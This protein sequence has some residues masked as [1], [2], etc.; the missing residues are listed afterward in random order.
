MLN[1][2]QPWVIARM[3]ALSLAETD[4][5]RLSWLAEANASYRNAWDA[6]DKT[7]FH[8]VREYERWLIGRRAFIRDVLGPEDPGT[9]GDV[10]EV[11][12]AK[13][14]QD[15]L[16]EYKIVVKGVITGVT[17]GLSPQIDILIVDPS[18][19]E[20]L[21]ELKAIPVDLVVAAFECKLSLRVGD[22]AK[23]IGTAR[24]LKPE[25]RKKA[26]DPITC[27]PIFYGLLGLGCAIENRDKLPH[28]SVL[29]AI[30]RHSGELANSLDMLDAVVV[31]ETFCVTANPTILCQDV[32]NHPRD[33]WLLRKYHIQ[34]DPL[35]A[36]PP[37]SSLGLFLH[38]LFSYLER[39]DKRLASVRAMYDLFTREQLHDVTLSE[40]SMDKIV[41]LECI[42]R[43]AQNSYAE[44]EITFDLHM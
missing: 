7:T 14:L 33:M 2:K 11:A 20:P 1:T 35:H 43:I 6:Q 12:W 32:D 30:N 9:A 40:T 19:P 28:E 39:S 16:P 42:D 29:D 26:R 17:Q 13:V 15:L 27:I 10:A 3:A 21:R 38:K 18:C 41:P 23:A 22:I 44:A 36:T 24:I 4:K 25:R 8:K 31:P 34:G 5:E 37:D